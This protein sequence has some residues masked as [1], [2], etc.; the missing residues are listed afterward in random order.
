[1]VLRLERQMSICVV[2]N[3]V[4]RS[5][6][7]SFFIVAIAVVSAV[8]IL[9]AR[10]A[11]E[12]M[13]EF[14]PIDTRIPDTAKI[15]VSPDTVASN[16]PTT[17]QEERAESTSTEAAPKPKTETVSETPSKAP[18]PDTETQA[19]TPVLPEPAPPAIQTSPPSTTTLA[20][21]DI[22]TAT[23]SALVNILCLTD[24][25]VTGLASIS[26]SG[27]MID[28]R[29][30]ILTNA[31][32]GQ[33]F[34]L[35]D[36]PKEHSVNC[37]IRTGSPATVAY[38]AKLL[39]ISPEWIAENA[40]FLSTER[41]MGTGEHDFAL[42]LI[43]KSA[44]NTTVPETLPFIAPGADEGFVK[45]DEV[46]VGAYPAGFLGTASIEK[47]L[48][49]ATSLVTIADLFT[50]ASN[51]IDVMSLGGSVVAQQGSSGGAVVDKHNKLLGLISTS[52]DGPTTADRDLR[53]ITL[54]YIERGLLASNKTTLEQLLEGDIQAKADAFNETAVPTLLSIM[55][56]ELKK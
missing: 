46:L 40:N 56:G 13:P 17:T 32:I 55:K 11:P 27:I 30:V 45:G 41:P 35:K 53:A 31:H 4:M 15:A 16:T 44:S 43:D 3:G 47:E 10:H 2:Y 18:A 36:Y 34:L 7:V 42:L 12:D 48:Y 54:Q 29:G 26:G 9:T 5:I 22:N 24:V 51:T 28:P 50:F 33:Y 49:S 19:T 6:F 38:A 21:S 25:R 52:S 14:I 8:S 37:L 23:R 20:W 1:M 39:Y